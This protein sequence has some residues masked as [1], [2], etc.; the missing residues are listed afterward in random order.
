MPE[1]GFLKAIL[2]SINRFQGRTALG[3]I[4]MKLIGEVID[5]V[6]ARTK[7]FD[8]S[9]VFQKRSQKRAPNFYSSRHCQLLKHSLFVADIG[10]PLCWETA[11]R[12]SKTSRR[13][14]SA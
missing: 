12:C 10:H 6:L 2:L 5:N 3:V 11:S 8:D 7:F 9:A 14:D 4:K 1:Q 13:T